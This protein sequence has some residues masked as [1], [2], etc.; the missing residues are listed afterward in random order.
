MDFKPMTEKRPNYECLCLLRRFD[1]YALAPGASSYGPTWHYRLAI[2]V[3]HDE[4]RG[5]FGEVLSS[6]G[7][8]WCDPDDES[9][10][11]F[12]DNVDQEAGYE[13][14]EWLELPQPDGVRRQYSNYG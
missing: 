1:F 8:Y 11:I 5:D 9:D 14:T 7:P 12:D 4:E 13:W 3:P 10:G 6:W 2:W